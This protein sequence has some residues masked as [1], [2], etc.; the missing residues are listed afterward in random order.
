MSRRVILIICILQIYSS[1]IIAQ[2]KSKDL[3]NELIL[4]SKNDKFSLDERLNDAIYS[5]ELANKTENDS[6]ILKTNRN[7]SM[8]YFQSEKFDKYINLNRSNFELA[9]KIMDSSAITVAGSNL[10]SFYRYLEKNDSSYFFYSQALK[11]YPP[12]DVSESKATA[13][14]YLADIQQIENI[15][16]GAEEAAIKSIIILN[17]LS[18]TQNRLDK[19][20]NAHNL[21]GIISRELGNYTKA[22][23][24]YDKSNEYA[25]RIEG[26]FIN[27]VYSINNKAFVYRKMGDF[28]KAI[29]L[30]KSLIPLRSKYEEIDSTFYPTIIDNIADT[31]LESGD[32][33]FDSVE[34]KFRESYKIA[35][36]LQDEVLKMNVALDISKLYKEINERDSI[37]KYAIE[38]SEIAS[39]VSANEVKQEALLILAE[40]SEGEKG[41]F[42]L[43]EH[44]RITDSLLNVERN[45]RNK[46]ARI[47][48]ETDELEAENEK[49]EAENEKISKENLYL[50]FISLG[51]LLTVILTYLFISQRAKNRKLKLIQVQQKAN[52]DIYNL[53]L[54]QQ[55]KVDEARAKEKIRVS[56]ELHDNI[57]GRLH[58]AR[59]TLDSLNFSEGKEVTLKRAKQIALI[60]EIEE[61]LRDISHE[62]N[63]DFVAGSGFVDIVEELI[64]TQTQAYNLEYDFNSDDG[65]SWDLIANKTKINVY[66]IIQES[67]QNI[68]KHAN[69]KVVKI[70]ISLEKDLICLDIIDDGDGFDTSRSKKGIGLKNMKSRVDFLNGEINFTSQSGNGTKVNVKIPYLNQNA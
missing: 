3:I 22:I 47:E 33:N 24:Y 67:M 70:S 64:E 65:I 29:E 15:Y 13:L 20:W 9:K 21:M 61:E 36:K 28:N 34:K 39:I 44:I 30:Y 52:E 4:K 62:L 26:G 43:K 8:R 7:L 18:E 55:D 54:G 41:K 6:V 45:V 53:M 49:I 60:K 38:A 5:S 69:A 56:K 57:L 32:Y 58:A 31:Q 66:R 23:E 48:F 17:K 51:L 46:Y 27:E 63:T 50:I 1:I 42:F 12:N 25:K 14:L 16:A 40:F 11:Y 2:S 35:S 19:L 59:F 37:Y 68:Y 10:G